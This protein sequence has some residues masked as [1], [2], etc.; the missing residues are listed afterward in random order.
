[1][2]NSLYGV[3][4]RTRIFSDI[5][6]SVETF[7]NEINTS[8]FKDVDVT[9][10]SLKKLYYMLYA[11]FGN[12]HIA[13]S[14]ENRFKYQLYYIIDSYGPTWERKLKIQY[15]F[16]HMSDD[17][18]IAGAKNIS[19]HAYNPPTEPST[20]TLEEL[21]E[22]DAQNTSTVKRS[23]IDA[24]SLLAVLLKD[25]MNSLFIEKF[26]KLFRIVVEPEAPLLYGEGEC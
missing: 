26:R 21:L 12:S 25:D 9:Q 22:I 16:R 24:M 17:E 13:S 23:K 3:Q 14:D 4:F 20:S 1:M 7:I 18:L 8:A 5:F 6:P 19:N 11:N 2:N 10:P 15:D